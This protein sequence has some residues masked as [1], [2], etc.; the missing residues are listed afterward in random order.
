MKTNKIGIYVS[1]K[2]SEI[3]LYHEKT[4]E[5]EI[6]GAKFPCGKYMIQIFNVGW[7]LVG[8]L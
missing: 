7:Q 1:N 3:I 4:R 2:S 8:W 5:V 6:E